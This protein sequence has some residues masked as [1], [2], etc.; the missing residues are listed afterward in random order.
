MAMTETLTLLAVHAHPD[1]EVIGTGGTLARYSA[2]GAR[3]ALVCAT[4]G[5]AGEIVDPTIDPKEAFPRLAA[6][7]EQEL[8]CACGIL[9]VHDILFLG[10]RDSGMAGAPDN[11]HAA[12]FC[13]ADLE[14]AAGHLVSI[15][16]E[17][18]PHVLVTYDAKG[19]YGHPDH[20]MAHR[21]TVRAFDAAGDPRFHPDDGLA[22]WQPKKLYFTALPRSELKQ[23][24][25]FLKDAGLPSPF[26]RPDLEPDRI[27][28]PDEDVTTRLDVRSHLPWKRQALECHRTQIAADSF[29]FRMPEEL[30]LRWWGFERFVRAR[31][32]VPAPTPEDDIFAGLR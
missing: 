31:S 6:I 17:V 9:G 29:F 10:Y 16:R 4:R 11:E 19:G 26:D 13:K 1:D 27:G 25:R 22:P 18:R 24:D 5:E 32:L 30:A 20:I 23:V 3:V 21:V 14:E 2:A 12:A 7:R 28:T 8:R 15:V